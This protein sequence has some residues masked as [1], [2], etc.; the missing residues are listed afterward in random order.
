[1]KNRANFLSCKIRNKNIKKQERKKKRKKKGREGGNQKEQ[2]RRSSQEHKQENIRRYG[3]MSAGA[4]DQVVCQIRS[5][6]HRKLI[7]FARQMGQSFAKQERKSN[8]ADKNFP[9]QAKR[10][11]LV[12]FMRYITVNERKKKERN[13]RNNKRNSLNI[14]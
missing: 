12:S 7:Q 5:R 2:N 6:R 3:K 9:F 1:M 10:G 8:N 4:A 14:A 13:G 11:M